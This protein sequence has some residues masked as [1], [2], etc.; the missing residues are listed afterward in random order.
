MKTILLLN[1]VTKNIYKEHIKTLKILRAIL[2]RIKALDIDN[3]DAY[4]MACH[5]QIEG[6]ED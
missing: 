6:L 2:N 1:I 4:A 3:D 5:R